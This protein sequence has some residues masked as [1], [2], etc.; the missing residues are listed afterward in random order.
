MYYSRLKTVLPNM[1]LANKPIII[2]GCVII[3]GE[4]DRMA[5]GFGRRS[6]FML[7]MQFFPGIFSFGSRK[8]RGP[9]IAIFA[10]SLAFVP[11]AFCDVTL[12]PLFSDG[13]VLQR[14]QAV[15][16]WGTAEPGEAVTV[17]INGKKAAATAGADGA[18]MLKLPSLVAGGPFEMV[19]KGKNLLVIHDVAVGEVWLASGQ[20]N[21]EFPL[22][23]FTPGNPVYGP[24]AREVIAAV[25]DPLLRM[26]TVPKKAAP[27]EP[28][29]NTSNSGSWKSAVPE[30]VGK[31]SA[32]GYYYAAELR[33]KLNVPVGIIHS[34]VGGTSAEAWTS[35]DAQETDPKL[36]GLLAYYDKLAA[37]YPADKKVYDEQTMPAYQAAVAEAKA[38]GKPEPKKPWPL[39]SP[40]DFNRPTTLFNGMI[41]PLIPYGIK[42]VIWYQGE[43]NGT[44]GIAYRRIF[45]TLIKDWRTRWN[46][47]DFPFLYVQLPSFTALQ[48]QP[49]EK[50]WTLLRE[51]QLMT[52]S[53]ANTGMASAIDLA[54][55][56]N[57]GELHPHNKA[58]VGRRLAL[59]AFA[60]VYGEKVSSFS[61]P[62]CSNVQFAGNEARLS[63][64][65]VDGGLMA[66]GGKL[67]GF[68]IAGKDRKF[69]WAEARIDGDNIVA[70]SSEVPEPTAVRYGWAMNPIGN[71]YNK[72]GLPASPFRTDFDAPE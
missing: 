29:P 8:A 17:T 19:V 44:Q 57:P 21:M 34:T 22:Q 15:P 10:F 1:C 69:V 35:R 36:R 53:V 71:L 4:K 28:V 72:E 13:A 62:L 67:A 38:E 39:K 3:D 7:S 42:G 52:L 40:M 31:F 54:D 65:H 11:A 23:T 24:K 61:G 46:Q 64:T 37:S 6:S 30:N 47:G 60:Q 33:R 48:K 20:S 66:K 12:S 55:P 25:N 14:G 26:F 32:V 27:D 41:S 58:E 68:A 49:I 16:V 5:R 50:G 18:W 2:M 45:P 43:A 59:I 70:S 51:A 56:E 63:F 9:L